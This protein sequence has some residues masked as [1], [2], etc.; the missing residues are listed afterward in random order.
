MTPL[1]NLA[2]RGTLLALLVSIK[3]IP[4]LAGASDGLCISEFMA[5]NVST[6]VPNA[7]TD[8]FDDWVE[9][10]NGS[11]DAIDLSGWHLTDDPGIPFKWDL[12]QM[13]L[14]SGGFLVVFA[15]GSGAVDSEGN[16]HT[17]FRIS[18]NGD[19][20]ALT[21]PELEVVHQIPSDGG[22]FPKQF[23][24]VSYGLADDELKFLKN[25]TPG[26]ANDVEEFVWVRDT[27]FSVRRGIYAEPVNVEITS[28][29]EDAV[30]RYTTDSTTPTEDNGE[31]YSGPIEISTTT[32]LKA[33]AFK[34]GHAPTNVDAQTYIFPEAVSIQEAP[35]DYPTRWGG[36]SRPDYEVD[37]EISM[38]DEYRE[39]FQQGL[40]ALP[41]VSVSMPVD[42][43][44]GTRGLYSRTTDRNLEKQGFAE[45]FRP[46]PEKDGENL[47]DGF[48]LECGVKIQGGASR[49][50]EAS[51]K[52]SMSLR[53][54]EQY[55]T[56]WLEYPLFDSPEAVTRFN[57][58]HLRAMYNNSWIH[59]DSGQRNR[60]TMIRDQ[61]MRDTMIAMGNQD[62][63]HGHYCHLYIN[64]LY[65]G[66]YNIHERLEN[67]NYATYHG[68]E[69]DS[70]VDGYN[71]RESMPSSL[72]ELRTIVRSRD[73][74]E[75]KWPEIERRLDI[76][77]YIDYY[78][79]QH[80]GHNDD[81][82]TDGNWRAAGGG[83]SESP[84]RMYVW[85]S[86]R[87]LENVRNTS[88]LGKSQDGIEFIR[89][90]DDLPEFQLRFS[91][92]LQ[93]HFA[94]G[95]ALTPDACLQRWNQYV[96]L[97]DLA[98]I[99]ES[100][101]WGD[102]RAPTRPY[103][104]DRHW[105]NAVEDVQEF[106]KAEEPNRTSYFRDKWLRSE[107]P[108]T[109]IPMFT[110]APDF[111]MGG[112]M[113]YGGVVEDGQMLSFD[114]SGGAVY[115]TLDGSDPRI[116]AMAGEMQTILDQGAA[117]SVFVP[118]DGSL[119][120][121]WQL[122]NFDDGQWTK[123]TTGIGFDYEELTGLDV[124]D[125]MRQKNA[126]IYIRVPFTIADQQ[127]LEDF[128][129]LVLNMK[130]EDGFVAY[131]NG[132][133]VGSS[134]APS[135]PQ[136]DSQ[137]TAS[138]PD[139]DAREF[140]EYDASAGVGALQV[141][142]NVLAIHLMNNSVNSSDALAMPQ[143][144]A[145]SASAAGLSPSAVLFSDPVPLPVSSVVNARRLT[146]TGW[147]AVNTALFIAEPLA[148]PGDV[149]ISEIDYHPAD[150]TEQEFDAGLAL[151]ESQTF[152]EDD[153]EFM[154]VM[155]TS[156]HEVNLF[157]SSFTD[158]VSLTFGSFVLQPGE[159]AVVVRNPEAFVARY[160][161][162]V[163]I[164]GV[165]E[166]SLSNGGESIALM[167]EAGQPLFAVDY[168]DGSPWPEVADGD[169]SSMV[170]NPG[171]DPTL[172]QSWVGADPSP[173]TDGPVEFEG[174]D[175]WA[176]LHFAGDAQSLGAP[177]ADPDKDTVVNLIEY[178]LKMNP[179]KA[180]SSMLPDVEVTDEQGKTII[181]MEFTP[182]AD[183]SDVV[184]QAQVS[185]D[186]VNWD[187]APTTNVGAAR[188]VSVER[189]DASPAYIRLSVS[190]K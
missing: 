174:Y 23:P 190:R 165:Y 12:P 125:I 167:S 94:P 169:G 24:D 37:Q 10:Y 160:G 78:L 3:A 68:I 26:A 111:M 31:T 46:N 43:M 182:N 100:A 41:V 147:S 92:R 130:Y 93:K 74:P 14:P 75:Q 143:L 161:T 171:A 185:S 55:G 72:R 146:G 86:E 159:R 116:P 34:D 45:Y 114:T 51:I 156:D 47:E 151:T 87:V 7:V 168:D 32:V 33:R 70:T 164:A 25:P 62:A 67:A 84:W 63:G 128:G 163:R 181:S 61:W 173:G 49:N 183:A 113:S 15:S 155:N 35:E 73:E 28:E 20:L 172:P 120:D 88:N 42:D 21:N 90:L 119:G 8:S 137:S 53:F 89:N 57:S 148:G 18:S 65:W 38:D 98:I 52:H 188:N 112:D 48:K 122:P 115:Y 39:R 60:A 66:V 124:A 141:G 118:V 170:L 133:E 158:G 27:N 77:N 110:P 81:L 44:F 132:V 176:A 56:D 162:S 82:K 2:T 105:V 11:S 109:D 91:D 107:W 104:R 80:F 131:I 54:R 144:L 95:G 187:D 117:A 157:G 19:F 96:E 17:N 134:N 177:N 59:R 6:D 71:P 150:P 102:D 97:L 5:R 126:T 1:F 139:S 76:D 145:G 22:S 101:R 79:A 152:E 64:G 123:G 103:T 184:V 175:A 179:N 142:T 108:S 189:L 154:E 85:D 50:V 36:E 186:L 166:G 121:A 30:I 13:E 69:D 180:D 140:E 83:S 9:I 106:F 149:T 136:W 29:T 153:F 16:A 40:R 178:A 138:H 58:I 99:C 4:S 127:A 129:T 135:P